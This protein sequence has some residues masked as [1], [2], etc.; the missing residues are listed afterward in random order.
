[1]SKMILCTASQHTCRWPNSTHAQNLSLPVVVFQCKAQYYF[2]IHIPSH[3][4]IQIATSNRSSTTWSCYSFRSMSKTCFCIKVLKRASGQ[5][6]GICCKSYCIFAWLMLYSYT[7]QKQKTKAPLSIL[8]ANFKKLL[9]IRPW[10]DHISLMWHWSRI[11]LW[12]SI[13]CETIEQHI[14]N[15]NALYSKQNSEY[16]KQI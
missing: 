13:I 4:V 5:M 3:I 2:P 8:E 1:M 6:A 7:L 15:I 10:R 14:L 11:H 12:L 16:L 9:W